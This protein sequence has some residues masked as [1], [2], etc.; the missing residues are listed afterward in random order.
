MA[1]V[2]E[3]A[4]KRFV[5]VDDQGDVRAELKAE[6][7]GLVGL[8]IRGKGGAPMLI[9]VGLQADETPIVMVRRPGPDGESFG[10]ASVLVTDDGRAGINLKDADGTSR[11]IYT[12]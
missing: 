4:A 2:D 3:V 6:P 8:H 1:P 12:T 10:R 7:D 11:N 5:L 9:V